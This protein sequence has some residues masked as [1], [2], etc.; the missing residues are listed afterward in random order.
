M[1]EVVFVEGDLPPDG[2]CQNPH[3][4]DRLSTYSAIR[5]VRS[6]SF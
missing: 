6:W 2:L 5:L 3:L 1:E 4:S